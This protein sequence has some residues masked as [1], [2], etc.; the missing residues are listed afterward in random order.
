MANLNTGIRGRLDA[1]L[2]TVVEIKSG[3][4]ND[5]ILPDQFLQDNHIRVIDHDFTNFG[6]GTT[7]TSPILFKPRPLVFFKNH[8]VDFS[9]ITDSVLRPRAMHYPT[10]GGPLFGDEWLSKRV[11]DPSNR[12]GMY[13][14][15]SARYL[16]QWAY[17]H[18]IRQGLPPGTPNLS[19]L[20]GISPVGSGSSFH[21]EGTFIDL[22]DGHSVQRYTSDVLAY[23]S[24]AQ[25]V[26][27]HLILLGT[28]ENTGCNGSMMY[29]ELVLLI[30]AMINR[31]YQAA[32]VDE[33]PDKEDVVAH[34]EREEDL[35]FKDEKSFPVLMVS[36]VRPQHARIFYT[37]MDGEDL[38]IRQ[39]EL[40]SLE[41]KNDRT[42]DFLS[43]FLL[44]SPLDEQLQ[45]QGMFKVLQP[46]QHVQG[47]QNPKQRKRKRDEAGSPSSS[48]KENFPEE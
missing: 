43:R 46:L 20:V 12:V 38:V 42:L 11:L 34:I 27:P 7:H 22:F 31:A 21:A 15:A 24:E 9:L 4:L 41:Q 8:Y 16:H 45:P 3:L 13:T 33:V 14:E 19:S 17:G 32:V 39:S 37:C 25:G 5:G 30:A 1:L 2:K 47:Q 26:K 23:D 35:L 28:Q 40:Y 48:E 6:D 18:G 10:S 29:G 44:S 36:V